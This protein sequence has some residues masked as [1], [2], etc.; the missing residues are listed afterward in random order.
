MMSEKQVYE[1]V[2]APVATP[3]GGDDNHVDHGSHGLVVLRTDGLG[4]HH[5]DLVEHL[6]QVG[7]Y[8]DDTW[9]PHDH[10]F[11]ASLP[12][13]VVDDMPEEEINRYGDN[14]AVVYFGK[15]F[16]DDYVLIPHDWIRP[17]NPSE[18]LAFSLRGQERIGV[19]EEVPEED[20]TLSRSVEWLQNAGRE[21]SRQI[22]DRARKGDDSTGLVFTVLTR[23]DGSKVL[24]SCHLEHGDEEGCRFEAEFM[25]DI[26]D[27]LEP[28]EHLEMRIHELEP[29]RIIERSQ[30]LD[31]EHF[32]EE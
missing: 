31:P 8:D 9:E 27:A 2:G 1:A 12:D 18:C 19:E 3:A 20:Q 13:R 14:L 10:E 25:G 23:K 30:P 22:L 24:V 5:P 16:V 6:G 26:E 7:Y 11:W 17:A 29:T 21:L 32:P 28:G 4:V 15:P